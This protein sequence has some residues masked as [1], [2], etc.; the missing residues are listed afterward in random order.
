VTAARTAAA[1]TTRRAQKGASRERRIA[2]MNRRQGTEL[3]ATY[4]HPPLKS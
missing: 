4:V 2:H 1:A 3:D